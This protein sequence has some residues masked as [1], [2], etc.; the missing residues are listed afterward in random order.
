MF[1][2]FP[3]T[4]RMGIQ[5]CSRQAV[6]WLA[7]ST[8]LNGLAFGADGV[9][10]PERRSVGVNATVWKVS[11]GAAASSAATAARRCS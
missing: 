6:V 11:A 7:A 9:I 5:L 2:A 10:I 3:E 8:A 4:M 1:K